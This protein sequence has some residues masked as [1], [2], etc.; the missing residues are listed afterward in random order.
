MLAFSAQPQ[1]DSAV[2]MYIANS[3]DN[4]VRCLTC[5]GVCGQSWSPLW[6]PQGN[7]IAFN[8]I[9]N[10]I[11]MTWADI[12]EFR[13]NKIDQRNLQEQL[14]SW[15][16]DREV[17]SVFKTRSRHH[18]FTATTINRIHLQNSTRY[19]V[20]TLEGDITATFAR[21]T[22]MIAHT[23]KDRKFISTFHI[24]NALDRKMVDIK[25][26]A[27]TIDI[28]QDLSW[29]PDEQMLAFTTTS[30]SSVLNTRKLFVLE[31]DK[32]EAYYLCKIDY[33]AP[34]IWSP[35]S[36]HIAYIGRR[37]SK[38]AQKGWFDAL[39]VIDIRRRTVN[40][41]IDVDNGRH[42]DDLIPCKPSWLSNSHKI[43]CGFSID[44][45]CTICVIDI[46]R[47]IIDYDF[48]LGDKFSKIRELSW[49][50]ATL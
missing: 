14:L 27:N 38:K 45:K 20:I 11:S 35:D 10:R 23:S 1:G 43:A 29:S 36:N 30:S 21:G 47:K 26:Q 48:N 28:I 17:L 37:R 33:D 44:S 46:E 3:K 31:R 40:H 25:I 9:N 8:V 2:H 49:Q 15:F 16:S 24:S 4:T 34:F 6:S 7:M 41:I 18:P 12:E 50:T 5:A 19:K 42:T 32:E 22:G 13:L 39:F